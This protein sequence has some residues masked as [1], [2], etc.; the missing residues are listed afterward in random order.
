MGILMAKWKKP[1]SARIT[2]ND[3]I[4]RVRNSFTNHLCIYEEKKKIFE[5]KGIENLNILLNP[6]RAAINLKKSY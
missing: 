1:D 2:K 6:N 5:Y 4:L 3:E